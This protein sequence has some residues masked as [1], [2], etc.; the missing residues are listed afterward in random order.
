MKEIS[1]YA[2]NDNG[3]LGSKGQNFRLRK[4]C[5]P[6][7]PKPV[8]PNEAKRNEESLSFKIYN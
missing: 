6:F 4:F 1:P 8:I 5:L 7:L 3:M 2:R